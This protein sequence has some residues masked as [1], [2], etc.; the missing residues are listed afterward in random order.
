MQRHRNVPKVIKNAQ[1]TKRIM[2]QAQRRKE[3]NLRRHSRKGLIPYRA[4]RKKPIVGI[5]K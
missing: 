5:A 3:E 4:E 2:L 1:N